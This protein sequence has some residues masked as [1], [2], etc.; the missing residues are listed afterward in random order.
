[1]LDVA[2]GIHLALFPLGRCRQCDNTEHPRTDPLGDGLDGATFASAI[3]SLEDNADFQ[4]L[5]HHP[6]L[7]LDQFDVQGF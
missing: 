1:M 6:L 4:T 2:L 7:Q 3:A 5:G